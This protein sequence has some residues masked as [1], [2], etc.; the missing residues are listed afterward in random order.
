MS[1]YLVDGYVFLTGKSYIV[2]IFLDKS[3]HFDTI[4][5]QKLYSD[6]YFLIDKINYILRVVALLGTCD[7]TKVAFLGAILDFAK[8]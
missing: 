1:G 5:G 6:A 2:L 4:M 3:R 8:N 7:V